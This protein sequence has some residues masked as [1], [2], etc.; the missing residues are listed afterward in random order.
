MFYWLQY[1]VILI[2]GV[3]YAM[4]YVQLGLR[5]EGSENITFALGS[6]RDFAVSKQNNFLLPYVRFV[7]LFI[8]WNKYLK[9]FLKK[10]EHWEISFLKT[11]FFY[12]TLV[13]KAFAWH[14]GR[15]SHTCLLTNYMNWRLFLLLFGFERG[16]NHPTHLSDCM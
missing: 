8:I 12:S 14:W 1:W 15:G 13:R 4:A 16:L 10:Q 5:K 3:S 7:H 9:Q 2:I 6:V 11:F